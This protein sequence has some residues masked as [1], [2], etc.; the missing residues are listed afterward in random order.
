LVWILGRAGGKAV[1]EQPYTKLVRAMYDLGYVRG[2]LQTY[3]NLRYQMGSD[4]ASNLANALDKVQAELMAV[5]VEGG[6]ATQ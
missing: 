5:F 2:R 4:V 1:S 6:D 3:G